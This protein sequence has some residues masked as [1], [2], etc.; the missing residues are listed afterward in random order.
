M[1]FPGFGRR[2]AAA[3][4][5]D[6]GELLIQR[7]ALSKYH[8]G[9]LWANTCCTHPHWNETLDACANRR[10]RARMSAMGERDGVRVTYPRIEFCTDNAAMIALLGHLRLSAGQHDDLAIRARARWPMTELAAPGA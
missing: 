10:L 5:F 6:R 9:G 1:R 8:C 7:R 2:R 4:V 3:F